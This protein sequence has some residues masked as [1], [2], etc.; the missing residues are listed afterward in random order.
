MHIFS[1]D[2]PSVFGLEIG[3]LQRKVFQSLVTCNVKHEDWLRQLEIC[4]KAALVQWV[5]VQVFCSAYINHL[6]SLCSVFSF[7]TR[8]PTPRGFSEGQC[9]IWNQKEWLLVQGFTMLAWTTS[10]LHILMCSLECEAH[11]FL[12]NMFTLINT[13]SLLTKCRTMWD[14]YLFLPPQR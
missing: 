14:S 7:Y 10:Y 5:R 1:L 2:F 11:G 6:F 4:F 13:Q 9:L 12:L 8:F 3:Y